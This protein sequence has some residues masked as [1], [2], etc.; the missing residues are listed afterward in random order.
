MLK[1]LYQVAV[2]IA[3]TV[4]ATWLG[5]TEV[6]RVEAFNA[7]KSEKALLDREMT[8]VIAVHKA[9]AYAGPVIEMATE[10]ARE[11]MMF[12][13]VVDQARA[14]VVAQTQELNQTRE[15]LNSSM[16]LMQDQIDENNRC[17]DHIRD[18]EKYT[19]TLMDKIP[20][21]DCPPMPHILEEEEGL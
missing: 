18:L 13:G 3:L 9:Q 21:E 19:R 10:L 17:V 14:T 2:I 11:N 6:T 20:D 12:M 7:I 1:T 8:R 16:E 5:Y 4:G 15:A